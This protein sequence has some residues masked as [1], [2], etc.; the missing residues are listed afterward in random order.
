MSAA[1]D[2]G[3]VFDAHVGAEFE[4]K[5]V[6]AT[7]ATMTADPYVWH[8]PTNMGGDG[9][10]SVRAFYS[11]SFVGKWP[12]DT[13]VEQVSRTIGDGRLVEELFISFTHDVQLDV[14]L[15]G[16]PP[17]GRRVELPVVVVMGFDGDKVAHEHIYW[18]QGS[19]VAQVGLIDPAE[20]PVAPDQARS[21][22]SHLRSQRLGS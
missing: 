11:S 18:D 12:A 5:D 20:V 7:M 4:K 17:T 1:R 14:L 21:L 9:F 19:L 16:V 15:P 22:R 10:E 2:L 8:V 3:A 6:D 13:T